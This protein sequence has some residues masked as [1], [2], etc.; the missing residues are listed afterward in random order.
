MDN[1]KTLVIGGSVKP[2]RFSNKAIN[3]L[4][5]YGHPVV[6]VGLRNGLVGDV[7]IETGRPDFEDIHTVTMYVGPKNQPGFYDYLIGLKPKRIIFNPGTENDV[8]EEM[9]AKNNIET[10]SHCTLVML[11]EGLF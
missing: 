6:S 8:F 10:I 7:A 2:E 11:D 5:S 3:K 4:R 1:K 9:A